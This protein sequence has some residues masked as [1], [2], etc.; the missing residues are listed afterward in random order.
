MTSLELFTG[1]PLDKHGYLFGKKIKNSLSP[2]LHAVIYQEL[3]LRWAQHRLDSDDIAKF[4]Q[5]IK[6]PDFFGSQNPLSSILHIPSLSLEVYN[7]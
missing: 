5:L 1:T 6:H 7:Y 2:E 4:L 3:G